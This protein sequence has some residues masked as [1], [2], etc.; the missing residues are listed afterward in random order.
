MKI[1]FPQCNITK[2]PNIKIKGLVNFNL[3]LCSKCNIDLQSMRTTRLRS[4]R[5]IIHQALR[6]FSSLCCVVP[7]VSRRPLFAHMCVLSFSVVSDSLSPWIVIC[8]APLFMGFSRQEFWS[9][10]PLQDLLDLR[11]EAGSHPLQADYLPSEPLGK[12]IFTYIYSYKW[13]IFNAFTCSLSEI[14]SVSH[15]VMPNSLQP[16]GL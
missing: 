12:P 4:Y 7:P 16:N 1:I 10:L 9:G 3:F 15:L 11:I 13:H 6:S 14:E 2:S 8:Q 5:L